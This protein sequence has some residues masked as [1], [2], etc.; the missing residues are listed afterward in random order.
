[1]TERRWRGF[2][3]AR[4]RADS[5]KTTALPGEENYFGTVGAVALDKAG[6]LAAGTSTGG[7]EMKRYGRVGD[8][9]I[10]GAGTYANNL[11]CAVSGTGDGEF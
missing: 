2:E 9:P 3:A 5:G 10:I 6:N 4:A 7:T 8:S 1:W 11:S